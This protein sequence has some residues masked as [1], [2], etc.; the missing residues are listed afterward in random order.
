MIEIALF[1]SCSGQ[2][3]CYGALWNGGGKCATE[4]GCRRK[5]STWSMVSTQECSTWNIGWVWATMGCPK[6]V[7]RRTIFV[8]LRFSALNGEKSR[9]NG[10]LP[11]RP[12]RRVRLVPL[13]RD[14]TGSVKWV[15][16]LARVWMAG[17]SSVV[18]M[19]AS[20]PVGL[21]NWI[22]AGIA[23]RMRFLASLSR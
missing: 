12:R 15:D 10:Y 19:M 4:L 8:E 22:A 6:I 17:A 7:P 18:V 14:W 21:S 3:V 5:C 9:L 2:V 11:S 13:G 16:W 20:Q 1:A 23:W